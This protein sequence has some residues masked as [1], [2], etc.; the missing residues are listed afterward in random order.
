MS[1]RPVFSVI[2]P[3]RD[4]A[5][6]L[7]W[8]LDSLAA[9]DFPREDY[10]VIVVDDGGRD[11]VDDVVRERSRAM[12]V[13]LTRIS[14]AGPGAARNAG[15]ALS[16]GK[17]LAFIDDDCAAHPQWLREMKTQLALNRGAAVGK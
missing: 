3:T 7:G 13:A 5:L 15:V 9:L 11:R 1:G 8:C 4:R 17:L 14:H 2:V 6:R 12:H 16:R 10:E